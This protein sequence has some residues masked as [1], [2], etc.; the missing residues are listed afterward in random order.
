MD[1]GKRLLSL[2][3]VSSVRH[4]VE[5]RTYEE[6]LET[7]GYFA[8]LFEQAFARGEEQ[9]DRIQGQIARILAE[10]LQPEARKRYGL[11]DEESIRRLASETFESAAVEEWERLMGLLKEGLG[12]EGLTPGQQSEFLQLM[13][14]Y[15][16]QLINMICREAA[17]SRSVPLE[18]MNELSLAIAD[19]IR[20]ES[21]ADKV[22]D[23]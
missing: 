17:K 20:E 1:H 22:A 7:G 13:E 18:N 10:A 5:P 16:G 14:G 21:H 12:K 23:S 9:P 3:G 8:N 2:L 6:L 19:M 4:Y 11:A 15:R